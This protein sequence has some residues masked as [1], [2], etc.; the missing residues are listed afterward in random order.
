MGGSGSDS[1]SDS[2]SESGDES[3]SELESSAGPDAPLEGSS[4][5]PSRENLSVVQEART[6]QK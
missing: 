6:N 4:G 5:L 1:H 3:E 2:S